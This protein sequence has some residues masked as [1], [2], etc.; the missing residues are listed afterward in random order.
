MRIINIE[1]IQK[2]TKKKC[3]SI[4]IKHKKRLPAEGSLFF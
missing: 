3:R 4:L 2:E 1:M